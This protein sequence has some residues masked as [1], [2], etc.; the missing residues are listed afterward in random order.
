M[1]ERTDDIREANDLLAILRQQAQDATA[2][3][4]AAQGEPAHPLIHPYRQFRDKLMDFE[5]LASLL[6]QRLTAAGTWHR[7]A[8]AELRAKAAELGEQFL[9]LDA[10]MVTLFVRTTARFA[11]RLAATPELPLGAAE[12]L[13]Q[14]ITALQ[15]AAGRLQDGELSRRTDPQLARE[16]EQ[17]LGDLGPLLDKAPKLPD[18]GTAAAGAGQGVRKLPR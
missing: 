7:G 14:D 17:A 5:A 18:F 10:L 3:A 13:E 1:A 9:L 2:L 8:R 4:E 12:K 16:L 15:V 6:K 11:A